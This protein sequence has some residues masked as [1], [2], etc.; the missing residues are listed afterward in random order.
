MTQ[1]KWGVN[2]VQTTPTWTAG[3]TAQGRVGVSFPMRG[4]GVFDGNVRAQAGVL[5]PSA[6]NARARLEIYVVSRDGVTVRGTAL[7]IGDYSTGTGFNTTIRNKTF[8]DGDALTPVPYLDGDRIV[9]VWGAA[10]AS[11]TT[12]QTT[13]TFGTATSTGVDLGQN[14]TDTAGDAWVEF[15]K[16]IDFYEPRYAVLDVFSSNGTSVSSVTTN[17][18]SPTGNALQVLAVW[19]QGG[20]PSATVT[21]AGCGLT[22]VQV[23]T[24]SHGNTRGRVTVL[25]A[26]KPSPTPGALTLTFS[27]AVQ[28]PSCIWIEFYGV[29]ISGTDGSAA[30]LQFVHSLNAVTAT[31]SF[32][33]AALAAGAKN[34]NAV[35]GFIS[36]D[37]TE[38][39]NVQPKSTD[40][41]L[42]NG[43]NSSGVGPRLFGRPTFDTIVG[44]TFS[45]S[46]AVPFIGGIALEL[47]TAAV[48][49]APVITR[50]SP[51]L[52]SIPASTPIVIDV[53]DL[54]GDLSTVE[55]K[56]NGV[57]V[58]TGA[59]AGAFSTGFTST[60]TNGAVTSGRRYTFLPD[61][62]TWSPAALTINVTAVDA[63]GITTTASFTWNATG[64]SPVVTLV[65]PAN[66]ATIGPATDPIV[67]DVT[68]S[69]GDLAFVAAVFNGAALGWKIDGSG[70]GVGFSLSTRATVSGGFRY[71][72]RADG[73]FVPGA[74][75]L[76]VTG[77]DAGGRSTTQTYSFTVDGTF[78]APP[79]S[80]VPLLQGGLGFELD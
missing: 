10:D 73:G 60:S 77:L 8:A 52:G 33:I 74:L 32:D 37:V 26:M 66:L 72:F 29:D 54:D 1:S 22:F 12:P 30:I 79:P 27:G 35:L 71:T 28:R 50:Q 17:S 46:Y 56:A 48:P 5:A 68:D 63:L 43:L 19:S 16:S 9:V 4:P 67:V 53:T 11:G 41:F 36:C 59:A 47:S 13:F 57:T 70:A 58:R 40:G 65:S 23:D 3:Q 24:F 15:S 21:V 51:A 25:R 18:K 14:E 61:A 69:D 55:I 78:G 75:T 31:G 39:A 49:L 34:D 64:A 6:A 7:A 76:A 45:G 44:E 62:G 42:V 20:T 2:A 80:I 38:N